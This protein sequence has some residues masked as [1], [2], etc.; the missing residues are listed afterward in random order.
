M[1]W[2]RRKHGPLSRSG[3]PPPTAVRC[4]F[5]NAPVQ[6]EPVRRMNLI[7]LHGWAIDQLDK[8]GHLTEHAEE[9][10]EHR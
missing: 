6:V 2:L 10:V 9:M 3:P 4:P 7:D 5:C 1:G 8:S